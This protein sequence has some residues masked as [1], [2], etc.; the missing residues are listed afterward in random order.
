MSPFSNVIPAEA[1]IHA[2]AFEASYANHNRLAWM[3][4]FAGMTLR[5]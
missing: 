1:G 5:M 4:A 3:P 2:S